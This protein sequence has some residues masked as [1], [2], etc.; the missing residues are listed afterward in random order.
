MNIPSLSTERQ[1]DRPRALAI[2]DAAGITV[3][4]SITA[5]DVLR[6]A[7]AG[8][9][10]P[11]GDLP[12]RTLSPPPWSSSSAVPSGPTRAVADSWRHQGAGAST[13]PLRGSSQRDPACA[14]TERISTRGDGRDAPRVSAP[15]TT[16]SEA[17]RSQPGDSQHRS[18]RAFWRRRTSR[19]DHRRGRGLRE[20]GGVRLRTPSRPARPPRDTLSRTAASI[21]PA[22]RTPITPSP[23]HGPR[24][25][26]RH[27]HASNPARKPQRPRWGF[28]LR[29][30]GT[31]I[32]RIP[33]D[34]LRP[35]NPPR[36]SLDPL[37]PA[38]APASHLREHH[39]L[40]PGPLPPHL[41]QLGLQAPELRA[42][43]PPVRPPGPEVE[44][45]DPLPRPGPRARQGATSPAWPREAAVTRREPLP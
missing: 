17:G 40:P 20:V 34:R 5:A 4:A 18:R 43:Q 26:P 7:P 13:R 21:L 10:R 22:A 3:E 11:V 30:D 25:P 32:E 45:H 35:R 9:G 37:P 27:P 1:S 8:S 39:R 41:L 36:S 23:S 33:P 6:R 2:S 12:R 28:F 14:S 19:A 42:P 24:S 31:A 15:W 38:T 16:N 44:P 29:H